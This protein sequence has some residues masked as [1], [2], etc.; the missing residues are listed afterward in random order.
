MPTPPNAPTSP[1]TTSRA[2]LAL[3]GTVT[4]EH[5][6]GTLRASHLAA[7]LGDD[8]MELTARAKAALDPDRIL[9]PGKWV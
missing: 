7:Q 2:A 9:N 5:G 3:G 6:I 1:S 8:V 4:G